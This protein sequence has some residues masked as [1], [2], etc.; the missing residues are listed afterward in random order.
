MHITI[1]K[2]R[3]IVAKEDKER[4]N[5]LREDKVLPAYPHETIGTA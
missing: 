1:D 4:F 5:F 3:R 2:A